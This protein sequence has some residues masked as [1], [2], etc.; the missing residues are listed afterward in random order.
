VR[1]S[2]CEL[3]QSEVEEVGATNYLHDRSPIQKTNI[4]KNLISES[5]ECDSEVA[6]GFRIV[7]VF[8]FRTKKCPYQKCTVFGP[9]G[10][11]HNFAKPLWF[12]WASLGA[13][14]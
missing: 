11:F 9:T 3:F 7:L 2:R 13:A 14:V 12:A 10:L 5:I 1:I 6:F 4:S 8:Q